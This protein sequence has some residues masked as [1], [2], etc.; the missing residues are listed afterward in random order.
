VHQRIGEWI[1]AFYGERARDLAAELAMHFERAANSKQAV[2]YLQQAAENDIRRFAYRE[3]VALARRGLEL[4]KRLPDTLERARQELGLYL[5]LG[6]P[7]IATEGYAAAEVGST[8]SKARELCRQLGE[9]PEFPQVLWGLWT[10]YLVRADLGTALEIAGE[11]SRVAGHIPYSGL[12]MEVTLIH[13]GE[14]VPAM[15]H[16]ERALS[17]YDPDRHRDDSFRYSQNSAV[18]TQSHAAWALWF[19]GQPDQALNR[20]QKALTLAHDL[21]EPH[22]LA[23]AFFFSS[24]L[25]QL[26]GDKRLAREHAEASLAIATEHR[27]LL[28]QAIA[29]ITRSWAKVEPGQLEETDEILRGLAAHQATGTELL[30]PHFLGLLAEALHIAGRSEEA[31][32][33]LDEA[34]ALARRNTELYYEAE[35]YRLKGELLLLESTGRAWTKAEECLHQSMK[36]AQRQKARSLEL[37]AATSLARHYQHQA[38][39]QD[40][41]VLL[42]K[43]YSTFTE[44]FDTSD[45][46][47]AKALLHA[48]S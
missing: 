34:L 28:Y 33:V 44:G 29:T 14:F 11:F 45:L 6:V 43:I 22:G 4:V 23:H 42:T 30:R 2:R 36:I 41:R 3:A 15:E 40:A 10:F 48:L 1:E 27:L 8:Y 19:V 35:L 32:L 46:R 25:H 18:A 13:L 24:I 5:T 39:L 17:L 47:E 21:A 16:F 9:A 20:M 26:R 37:R 7:L 12:A 31:L 38:R